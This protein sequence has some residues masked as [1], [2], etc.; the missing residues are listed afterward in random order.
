MAHID[1][2]FR[3]SRINEAYF[4]VKNEYVLVNY[5]PG[6]TDDKVLVGPHLIEAGYPSLKGTAF[7]E[8]GIDCAFGSHHMDQ[9]FIFSGN[10]CAQINYAPHTTNDRIIKGP[11]TITAMFPF[12]KGTV[13]E[14]GVDAAFESTKNYE[15]YLFKDNQY[16]LINYD[17]DSHLI[18]IDLIN[19]GFPSLKNTYFESGIDAAFALHN[20]D[21]AYLFK[22]DYYAR[23][24][25]ASGTTE[26]NITGGIKKILT[27]WPS[28]RG[29]LPLKS[30]G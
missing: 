15:A 25:F 19:R 17:Y 10:L 29:I 13:F 16:A 4:F 23:I 8:P 20:T 5:A 3:S 14:N 1:A 12:F 7:A 9:A 27:Y 28:L 22:G 24:N 6:T 18:S 2:A 21:E 26:D 30:S 11:M